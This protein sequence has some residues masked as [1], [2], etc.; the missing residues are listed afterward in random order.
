VKSDHIY[1][2]RDPHI[3][4]K[5]LVKEMGICAQRKVDVWTNESNNSMSEDENSSM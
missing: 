2:K 1:G 3:C 4:E 5:T